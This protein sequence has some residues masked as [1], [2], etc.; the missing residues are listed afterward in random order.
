MSLI[1]EDSDILEVVVRHKKNGPV[2]IKLRPED[3]WADYINPRA[4]EMTSPEIEAAENA[5]YFGLIHAVT[6]L[7]TCI[8]ILPSPDD[9]KV[10]NQFTQLVVK[11]AEERANKLKD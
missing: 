4:M 8:Q 6:V 5:F 3:A 11:L 2:S 9:K 7:E 10:L 1:P